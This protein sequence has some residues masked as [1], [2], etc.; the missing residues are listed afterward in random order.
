ML[1]VNVGTCVESIFSKLDTVLVFC[2]LNSVS[3]V[4]VSEKGI[5]SLIW[6]VVG[7]SS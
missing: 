5:F 7:K 3:G 1:S 6:S 2:V 4:V